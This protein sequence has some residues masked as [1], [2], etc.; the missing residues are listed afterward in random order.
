VIGWGLLGAIVASGVIWWQP[1]PAATVLAFVLLGG[2]LAGVFP[3]LIA[4]TPGRIGDER[5]QHAIAWQVGAAAAGGSGISAV[6]GL[7]INQTSLAV[8][9]PAIV[10]LALL[11]FAANAALTRLA[12]IRAPVR[13]PSAADR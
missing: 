3:A 9:G 13:A 10:V 12:P 8:L 11:L 5:A 1:E 2:S 6:V 7:L 4:V